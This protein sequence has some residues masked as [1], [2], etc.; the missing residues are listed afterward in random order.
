MQRTSS[1]VA[2]YAKTYDAQWDG[3][4]AQDWAELAKYA[5]SLKIMGYDY[6][7]CTQ[8]P[9]PLAPLDWLE[10]VMNYAQRVVQET[11]I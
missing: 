7:W 4:G 1:S 2:I 6:H 5:D 3:A 8:H 11:P 10:A 9:G